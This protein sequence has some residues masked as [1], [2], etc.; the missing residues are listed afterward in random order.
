MV[1]TIEIEDVPD[2]VLRTLTSRARSAGVPLSEYVRELLAAVASRPSREELV[3]E[4]SLI[5]PRDAGESGAESVRAI[6]DEYD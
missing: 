5:E 4:L 2:D 6:R 3:A 1:V